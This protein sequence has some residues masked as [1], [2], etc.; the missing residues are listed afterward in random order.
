MKKAAQKSAPVSLG[1]KRNCPGCGTKFYDFGKTQFSCPKCDKKL[2]L[3]D[4]T[5]DKLLSASPKKAP[6]EGKKPSAIEPL[7]ESE[8]VVVED[9][10]SFE[11]ADDLE[12]GE[13][14]GGSIKVGNSDGGTE[15]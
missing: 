7:L 6:K 3:D 5:P 10:D 2:S 13:D 14:V 12:D 8:D 1:C 11:D 4:F 15:Y 9:A